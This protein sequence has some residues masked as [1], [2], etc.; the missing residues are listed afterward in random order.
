[1]KLLMRAGRRLEGL[2]RHLSSNRSSTR[3]RGRAL[4]SLSTIELRYA[5]A[6][7]RYERAKSGAI[8]SPEEEE[9]LAQLLAELRRREA[10]P[11]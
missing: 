8:S 7:W 4:A 2:L 1:M 6:L 11:S 10:P 5:I 3:K 9:H